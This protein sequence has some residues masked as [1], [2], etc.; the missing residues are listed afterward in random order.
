MATPLVLTDS[1]IH[2]H[3][4]MPIAIAAVQDA[5]KAIATDSFLAP[6]RLRVHFGHMTDI[7]LSVGGSLES[8]GV[9]GFRAYY[10][11]AARHYQDQVAAIWELDTG[12]LKGVILG[13]ALGI[14][15]MGAIGGVA[16]DALARPDAAIVAVIG[17][18]RQAASHL[19]A[20]AAVRNL[21]E[22]RVSSR[23]EDRC[24]SF[25]HQMSQKLGVSVLVQNSARDAVEG[26]DIVLLATTSLRPVIRAE[27]LSPGV[28]VH[29][30]GFKSRTGKEMGLDVAE[31]ADLLATDSPAQVAAAGD[32][33]ILHGTVHLSR[34]ID[35]A[36]V[37]SGRT[38]GPTDS[39]AIRVCYPMGIAGSEV[40]VADQLIRQI[41][42]RF[43][44]QRNR[45]QSQV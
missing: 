37:V 26:A 28:F 39:K 21:R 24:R 33:F 2:K 6:S 3:A 40:I 30:V 42:G 16:I 43:R 9:I 8:G 27:W 19:Q 41:E 32:T 29:T 38:A 15:R 13:E 35:L 20:A 17:A 25:A 31:R 14:L 7:I 18:G 4:D 34:I 11:R 23:H 5:F 44:S 10:S 12:R 22:V 45:S 36:E 1:D